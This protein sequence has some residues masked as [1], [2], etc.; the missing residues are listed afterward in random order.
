VHTS[1]P[2]C[3][4]AAEQNGA[5]SQEVVNAYFRHETPYWTAIYQGQG[6]IEATHQFR[7]RTALE[8]V[9]SLR[10]EPGARGLDVGCG[11]GLAAA[12]L[13]RRGL[14]VDALDAVETMIVAARRCAVE[15]GVE[16]RVTMRVGNVHALPFADETFSLVLALGVLPW[17][18]ECEKPLREMSRVLRRGGHLIASVDTR[19]Q[20]R[21]VLD[22]FASPLFAGPRKVAAAILGHRRGPADG[23]HSSVVALRDFQRVLRATGFQKVRGLALGFGPFTL[24]ERQ[25]LPIMIGLKLQDWLHAMAERGTP[26]IRSAGSQYL[27]LA[28][29]CVVETKA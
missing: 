23:A 5:P 3:E 16:G 21:S 10:L 20:L 13:A 1:E 27:V 26:I 24:F 29:K 8:M 14:Q 15:L 22:P 28:Q 18:P 17:L 4:T 7:L 19:W 12:E 11:A 6:I 25:V 2:E 9:D